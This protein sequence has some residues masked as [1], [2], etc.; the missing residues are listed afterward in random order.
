MWLVASLPSIE[1][2][3]E[4]CSITSF[5]VSA[6]CDGSP[7]VRARE[8]L[9]RVLSKA[10]EALVFPSRERILRPAEREPGIRAEKDALRA[11]QKS[12]QADDSASPLS[13]CW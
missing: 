8:G 5:L 13:E 7:R 2:S 9:L 4:A 3:S 11:F 12:K 6:S 10:D 1:Q